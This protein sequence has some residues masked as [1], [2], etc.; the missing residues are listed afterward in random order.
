MFVSTWSQ[1]SK[2]SIWFLYFG[3]V[4]FAC[5]VAVK[6]QPAMSL[7]FIPLEIAY[8]VVSLWIGIRLILAVLRLDEGKAPADPQADSAKAWSLFGPVLWLGALQALIIF[9]GMVLLIIPGIYL[10]IALSFGQM[11]L[12]EQNVRGLKALAAS[13][14]LVRGRWWAVLWREF[15][16]GLV[17]GAGLVLLVIIVFTLFG[18]IAGPDRFV[19]LMQSPELDPLLN[20]TL[21]LI[22]SIL[23]AALIPLFVGFQV[24]VY[25]A[26]RRSA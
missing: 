7:L 1:T 22:N 24:K 15:A 18:L 3:L 23:Q 26:L 2:I 19:L 9:G 5:Y 12:V 21:N 4:E 11:F 25:R 14:D 8:V 17:F 20:G 6:F 10:A 13:R 16:G